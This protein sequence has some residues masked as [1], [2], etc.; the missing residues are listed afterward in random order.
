[1]RFTETLYL[2]FILTSSK[3]TILFG[4]E[5][6][7]HDARTVAKLT[8]AILSNAK[9]LCRYFGAQSRTRGDTRLP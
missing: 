2:R 3:K 7:R 6:M 8:P 5:V 9:L 1:M 4:L